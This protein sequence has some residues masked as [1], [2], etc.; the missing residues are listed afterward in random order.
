MLPW[1]KLTPFERAGEDNRAYRLPPDIKKVASST[2]L[3]VISGIQHSFTLKRPKAAEEREEEREV[4]D[5][6]TDVKNLFERPLREPILG[7]HFQL[8]GRSAIEQRI[9]LDTTQLYIPVYTHLRVYPS[10]MMEA[11]PT[12]PIIGQVKAEN[13]L[14]HYMPVVGKVDVNTSAINIKE[15]QKLERIK[16]GANL[17]Q[18]RASAGW[19]KPKTSSILGIPRAGSSL[20]KA[21][22]SVSQ[23]SPKAGVSSGYGKVSVSQGYP[24]AGSPR[25]RTTSLSKPKTSS[26]PGK[27][28]ASFRLGSPKAAASLAKAD[29][30][31][32]RLKSSPSKRSFSPG[33]ANASSGKARISSV[34]GKPKAK[35]ERE[36]H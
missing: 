33:K 1:S 13:Y 27:P 21:R 34:L 19:G 30:S 20:G 16:A 3:K 7:K 36:T 29:S 2:T 15:P 28:K 25:P 22:A 17:D 26:S 12:S 6:T 24:R 8:P 23:G 9:E 31:P 10:E 35:S 11:L 5:T 32:G 18:P 14:E 4:E